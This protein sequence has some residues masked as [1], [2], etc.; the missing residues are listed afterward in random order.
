VRQLAKK[1]AEDDFRV[2]I[3]DRPN[4]GASG[5]A[6]HGASESRLN[7]D[8]LAGMVRELDAG[9]VIVIGDQRV[10]SLV[11]ALAGACTQLLE[12]ARH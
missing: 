10:P 8:A 6:F 3:W 4:Y 1:L 7:A 5:M 9:P 2:L 12:F 11:L